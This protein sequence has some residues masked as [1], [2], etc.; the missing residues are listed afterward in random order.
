MGETYDL[1]RQNENGQ[2]GF[3][4]SVVGRNN[5]KKRLMKLSSLK[6][7]T[8]MIYDSTEAKFIEPFKKSA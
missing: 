1:F 6:P 2:P 3:V 8:Y 4:E 5:L 7:G